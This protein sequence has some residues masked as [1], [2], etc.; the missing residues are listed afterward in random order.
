[1]SAPITRSRLLGIRFLLYL[2]NSVS[3]SNY[4]VLSLAVLTA[5]PGCDDV[6]DDH[7]DWNNTDP[8]D[9]MVLIPDGP[10]WTGCD[11]QYDES[12]QYYDYPFR[13]TSLPKFHIDLTEVTQYQ[14]RQCVLN[15]VC[16]EPH[17]SVPPTEWNPRN[18]PFLPVVCV[19]W[20]EANAYCGWAGKRLCTGLEWEK[21]ARGTDGRMYPWG[22][23]NATCEFAVMNDPS[24]KGKGCG[25]GARDQICSKSPTGDSPYGLCD[26]AGNVWEWVSDWTTEEKW[27]HVRR[28]GGFGTLDWALTVY[29]EGDTSVA[30][31]RDDNL[32]FRCCHD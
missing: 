30:L 28:G 5:M 26:M 29:F 1:M 19:G 12:C 14:Y 11:G 16:P 3:V 15:G 4:L 32:G 22:N 2:M 7:N 6:Q 10:F 31:E 21:A 20:D 23:A 27:A 8:L 17:C 25:S 24:N 9:G 18:E 13:Q